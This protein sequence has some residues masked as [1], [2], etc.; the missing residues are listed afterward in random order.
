MFHQSH[1]DQHH[2][3]S[4]EQLAGGVGADVAQQTV[5]PSVPAPMPT[6]SDLLKKA[7]V[8]GGI[9]LIVFFVLRELAKRAKK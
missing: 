7:L 3:A 1:L 8:V 4:T 6:G 9:A 5:A 2:H